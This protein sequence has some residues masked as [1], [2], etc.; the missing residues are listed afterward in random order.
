M[1]LESP[2]EAIYFVFFFSHHYFSHDQRNSRRALVL[3]LTFLPILTT[4][5]GLIFFVLQQEGRQFRLGSGGS[6]DPSTPSQ[7]SQRKGGW[8]REDIS[9]SP[10]EFYGLESGTL[11]DKKGLSS[12]RKSIRRVGKYDHDSPTAKGAYIGGL[13]LNFSFFFPPYIYVVITGAEHQSI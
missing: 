10:P 3:R 11:E 6:L 1:F 8:E 12:K 9:F 4:I 7:T 2:W 13:G 5:I